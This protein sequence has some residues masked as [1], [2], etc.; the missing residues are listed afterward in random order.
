M[1]CFLSSYTFV[2]CLFG[3]PFFFLF[4][5]VI[6]LFLSYCFWSI[7]FILQRGE[8]CCC[9][10]TSAIPSACLNPNISAGSRIFFFWA[11]WS[12]IWQGA[13]FSSCFIT[14]SLQFLRIMGI[15][16]CLF[17]FFLI[18]GHVIVFSHNRR[19]GYEW[20]NKGKQRKKVQLGPRL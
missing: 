12:S 3:P 8:M 10:A 15:I 5:Q 16:F 20:V 11:G 7:S 17:I 9:F 6:S 14:L 2:F 13:H 18:L 4:F 1:W 19:I